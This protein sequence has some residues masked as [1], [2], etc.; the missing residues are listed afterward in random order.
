MT[1]DQLQNIVCHLI[2]QLETDTFREKAR[3]NHSDFIRD[4]R[5][6]LKDLILLLLSN[7]TSSIDHELFR[8]FP[9]QDMPVSAAAFCKQRDKL[10]PEALAYLNRLM[11]NHVPER[12]RN[13][14]RWLAIDGTTLNL[15]N[16]VSTAQVFGLT[17]NAK[18]PQARLS[19]L[20][21]LSNQL[22]LDVQISPLGTGERALAQRHADVCKP[23]DLILA[24][25][26]Y[27][28]AAMYQ[29]WYD[30]E[31]DFCIRVPISQ[32]RL[33]YP[34]YSSGQ[35][36]QEAT[37]PECSR[38]VRLVRVPLEADED[39]VLVTSLLNQDQWPA[40]H[41]KEIY[42]ARW[43]IEEDYKTLKSR[44]QIEQF[45]GKKVH[46][47]LQDI[48]ATVIHKNIVALACQCAQHQVDGRVKK[49][50]V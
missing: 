13:G 29:Y 18:R 46:A 2:D 6:P 11:V 7:M 14:L 34:F 43:G 3:R 26:G 16:H 39:E 31:I 15:P 41:F 9:E 23:G 12:R 22:T 45:S 37:L 8:Y 32:S 24:D 35:T 17:A 38:P 19:Q 49:T 1:H 25:R 30:R 20:L 10:N 42:F 5:L 33:Y 47:V 44:L 21:D 4:R 36:E 50:S 48:Y 27:A 40:E 28:G